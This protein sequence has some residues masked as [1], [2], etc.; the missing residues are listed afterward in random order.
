MKKIIS[1]MHE[2]LESGGTREGYYA[3]FNTV[4]TLSVGVRYVM[5]PNDWMQSIVEILYIGHGVALGV[6][7]E[8]CATKAGS[9]G[10]KVL[11]V[12]E[13][14]AV[15]WVYSENRYQYRLQELDTIK[16]K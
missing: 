3:Q 16:R 2:F 9:K 15:G 8:S 6:E 14:A 5:M 12:A 11:F 13:G 4:K 1:S 10:R 7:V